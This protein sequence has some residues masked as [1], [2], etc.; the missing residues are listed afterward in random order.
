MLNI[1]KLPDDLIECV[2]FHGHLCPGLVYGYRVAN[3]AIKLLGIEKSE[4]EEIVCICENDSCAVDAFQKLLGTT[5]GKGNLIINNFGKNVYTIFSRKTQ[6]AFRFSRI[7]SYR[8]SGEEKK[9]FI[10]LEAAMKNNTAT[11]K[12]LKRQKFLKACDL[13]NKPFNELFEETEI[14]FEPPPY[15]SLAPS[16][17]CN[18]C[19]ELTMQ[20][21]MIISNSGNHLC[22]PCSQSE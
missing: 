7:F 21:K 4:D 3:E 6:R 17:A 11:K 12:E 10:G 13:A 14:A 20:T 5:A 18:K 1:S 22:M 19:G 16:V 15:A 9:E 2:N 8:Y